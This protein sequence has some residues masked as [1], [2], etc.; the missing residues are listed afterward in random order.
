MITV[1]GIVMDARQA[2]REVQEEA[3][4]LGLIPS[5]PAVSCQALLDS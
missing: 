1:N 2:P 3:F 5:L 4:R